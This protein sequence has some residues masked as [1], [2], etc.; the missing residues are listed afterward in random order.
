MDTAQKCC[1]HVQEG[2]LSWDPPHEPHAATPV[3]PRGFALVGAFAA[4]AAPVSCMALH[5]SLPMVVTGALRCMPRTVSSTYVVTD[6]G[7]A[8][9]LSHGA[10]STITPAS[11]VLSLPCVLQRSCI[12]CRECASRQHQTAPDARLSRSPASQP[13]SVSRPSRRCAG[14]DDCTWRMYHL[15]SAEPV[16]SGEGHTGWLSAVAFHPEA[17][18]RVAG[19]ISH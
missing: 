17:R 13:A 2:Q 10:V 16:V 3:D 11:H 18:T 5:P 19:Q 15:P 7:Q 1:D 14:S 9:A 6:T 8:L 12:T 4:H